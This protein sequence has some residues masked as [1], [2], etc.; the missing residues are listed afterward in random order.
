MS[1]DEKPSHPWRWALLVLVLGLC[2]TAWRAS[3]LHDQVHALAGER[4][5]Q[6]IDRL[7]TDIQLRFD[8]TIDALRGARGVV[9]AHGEID[10]YTFRKSLAS[11]NLLTELPGLRGIG[12]IEPVHPRDLEALIGR[13]RLDGAPDFAVKGVGGGPLNAGS[14]YIIRFVEPLADNRAAVGLDIA[15]ETNRKAAADLSAQRGEPALTG[16]ITLVQDNQ[17]RAGALLLLPV[18]RGGGVSTDPE[19]RAASLHGWVYS[20]LVYEELLNPARI[21]AQGM[22]RFGIAQLNA[23][24]EAQAVLT[25]QESAA[26]TPAPAL[27][28]FATTRTLQIAN[29]TFVVQAASTAL[30]EAGFDWLGPWRLALAGGVVSLLLALTIW[31]LMSGRNRALATAEELTQSLRSTYQQMELAN[32]R[33]KTV[34]EASPFGMLIADEKGSITLAN[35]AA[36]HIF[37]YEKNELIDLPIARLVPVAARAHHQTR[38]AEYKAAPTPRRMGANRRL[39]ACRKDGTEFPVEVGLNP[40]PVGKETAV[41]VTVLDITERAQTDDELSRYRQD[42]EAMVA[43]RTAEAVRAKEAAERAN[44]AKTVFLTNMSHELRTPLHAVLSFARLGQKRV[45]ESVGVPPK[46]AQYFDRISASGERLLALVS[47]LLDLSALEQGQR[48]FQLTPVA[49]QDLVANALENVRAAANARAINLRSEL[50]DPSLTATVDQIGIIDVLTEVLRNAITF[51][52]DGGDVVLRAALQSDSEQPMV[53]IEIVDHGIG[54]PE[55]ELAS[56]FDAFTQSSST[57]TGAGGKGLGLAIC[58]EI[59]SAHGGRISAHANESGGTC[60]CIELPQH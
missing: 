26:G 53:R 58:R 47:A 24:G 55:S 52:P 34:L 9:D 44:A 16:V 19:A 42:L 43:E 54:I 18:Y 40:L 57:E 25:S 1:K 41:L 15:S 39:N 35:A 3:V 29:Q 37:G 38:M 21:G 14:P 59:V 7:E 36:E 4:F 33:M 32:Q 17:Q 46:L 51:S 60:I 2:I 31:L 50:P 10:R 56:V 48:H 45:T 49:V 5:T 22:I 27:S 20:P 23:K 11:R 8:R 30:F 13:E 6:Q 28:R 12:V